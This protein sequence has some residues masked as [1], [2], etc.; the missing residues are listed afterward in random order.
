MP[1]KNGL[2]FLNEY[3]GSHAVNDNTVIYILSTD[4]SNPLLVEAK[5]HKS[6][7]GIF[8]KLLSEYHIEEI[9]RRLNL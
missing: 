9:L 4:I 6:V 8:E 7:A 1:F 3:S 5:S 2:D